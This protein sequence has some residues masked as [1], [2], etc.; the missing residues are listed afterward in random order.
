VVEEI[1]PVSVWYKGNNIFHLWYRHVPVQRNLHRDWFC[2]LSNL[3]G[4]ITVVVHLY[5]KRPAVSGQVFGLGSEGVG[6]NDGV[7]GLKGKEDKEKFTQDIM[8]DKT[9]LNLKYV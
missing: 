5:V 8:N 2:R 1:L 4:I 6:G 3:D 9:N 7:G